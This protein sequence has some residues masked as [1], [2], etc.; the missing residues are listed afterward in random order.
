M[1]GFEKIENDLYGSIYGFPRRGNGYELWNKIKSNDEILKEAI[2]VRK[3]KFGE[4]DLVKGLTI[5]D[6][7]LVDYKNVNQEIYNN[8]VNLIYSNTDIARIVLDGYGNGGYSYLLMTLWNHDLKLTPAQKEFAISEAMNKN[9]TI[10]DKLEQEQFEKELEERGYTDQLTAILELGGSKNPVGVKTGSLF[11]R[12][13]LKGIT[14]E[15][16]HGTLPFD[17]RYQILR[18]PNFTIEE[19]KKLVYDF[20]EADDEYDELLEQWEWDIINSFSNSEGEQL[21]ISELFYYSY[22]ELL[23]FYG[24][25]ETTDTVWS[26]IKFCRTMHILRPQQWEKEFNIQKRIS[27]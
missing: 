5:C 4:R 14:N 24:N 8:L 17:I 20:F 25:K 22:N 13:L 21:D 12:R 10:K 11:M 15:Q 27:K 18:N 26:E 19:K 16:A 1:A 9:G 2:E 6:C 7:M 3:D 23:D